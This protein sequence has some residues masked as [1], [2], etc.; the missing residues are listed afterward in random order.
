MNA[1]YPDLKLIEKCNNV[2]VPKVSKAVTSCGDALEKYVKIP[3]FDPA[4]VD[5]V[6]EILIEATNWCLTVEGLHSKMEIH[7]IHNTKRDTSEIGI[8]T[9]NST[10]TIFEFFQDLEMAIMGWENNQQRGN[11]VY[12]HHLSTGIKAKTVDKMD[13]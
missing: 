10:R 11:K 12:N 13:D 5:E 9:N 6:T 3:G 4:Y 8:F 7:S 2:D 1:D